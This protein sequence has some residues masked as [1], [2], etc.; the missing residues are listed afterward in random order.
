M[1]SV[2]CVDGS[3]LTLRVSPVRGR[4]DEVYEALVEMDLDGAPFGVIGERCHGVLLAAAERGLNGLAPARDPELLSL[5][6]RDPDDLTGDGALRAVLDVQ[7]RWQKSGWQTV[8]R[9]RLEAWGDAGFGRVA[10]LDPHDFLTVVET[11]LAD[12]Q[13]L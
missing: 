2:T 4:D 1:A 13:A 11:L 9:V 8:R 5:R 12:V 10:Y 3:V 7:R 6:A